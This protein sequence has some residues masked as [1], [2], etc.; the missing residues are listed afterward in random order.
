MRQLALRYA[1]DLHGGVRIKAAGE[2]DLAVHDQLQ[3]A[4]DAAL[5]KVPTRLRVDLSAVTFLDAGG[6]GILVRAACRAREAGIPLYVVG[7]AG[8]VARV[9]EISA[10]WNAGTG[11][12]GANTRCALAPGQLGDVL[13]RRADP[14]DQTAEGGSVRGRAGKLNRHMSK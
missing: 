11:H 13:S 9:L 1:G 7:A 2:I 4:L 10:G 5:Q 8:L 6:S 12:L 14:V 3:R